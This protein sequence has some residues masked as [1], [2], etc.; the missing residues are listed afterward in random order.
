MITSKLKF[1]ILFTLSIIWI[2]CSEIPKKKDS[3]WPYTQEEENRRR[4]EVI[5]DCF[6][7]WDGSHL[8]L[9]K[10][11]KESMN[12]PDSYKHIKTIHWDKN[13]KLYV[14]TTFRGKNAFG[15]VVKQTIL[16]EIA[17]DCRII[18]VYE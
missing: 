18:Q 5:S 6:S 4:E 8:E 11:I 12:D 9:T 17:L 2:G 1:L 14:E 10:L 16:A 3:K 7:A 13:G 15:G